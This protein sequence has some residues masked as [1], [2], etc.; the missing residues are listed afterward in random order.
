ML[1]Q[2]KL[3]ALVEGSGRSSYMEV[4]TRV[5]LRSDYAMSNRGQSWYPGGQNLEGSW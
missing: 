4:L 5:G 1:C 2:T 3:K